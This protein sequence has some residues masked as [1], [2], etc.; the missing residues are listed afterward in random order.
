MTAGGKLFHVSDLFERIHDL[1]NTISGITISGGEPLQQANALIS[2]LERIR[3]ETNL[4]VI[5]FTGFCWEEIQ[6]L[7]C[8]EVLLACVDVLLAGRYHARQRI[9]RGLRG[10]A[11]KTVHFL[12]ARYSAAD[13]DA[14]PEAE[15]IIGR[16]GTTIL[17]GIAPVVLP[18]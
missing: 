10:S 4:S 14:V 11:N 9:A 2:L 17:S 6:R 7:P 18:G 12:T 8:R 15:V 13:L 16:D 1:D 5:L 3:A